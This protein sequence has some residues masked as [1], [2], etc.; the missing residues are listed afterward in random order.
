MKKSK[1]ITLILITAALASCH[2]KKKQKDW[3]ENNV[4]MRS[5]TTAGYSHA[6]HHGGGVGNALLWYYAFRP[7]GYYSGGNYY[8]SGYYSGAINESANIGS[9]TTKSNI[10]RGGFG[11]SAYT[12]SS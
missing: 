7:Y 1:G 5:D 9:S 4:Y 12:V 3:V 11:A 6:Y 10:I 2:E 8:R